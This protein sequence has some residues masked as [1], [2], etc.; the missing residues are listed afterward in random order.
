MELFLIETFLAER[1]EPVIGKATKEPHLDRRFFCDLWFV[2]SWFGCCFLARSTHHK[3]STIITKSFLIKQTLPPFSLIDTPILTLPYLTFHQHINL[4]IMCV[5]FVKFSPAAS[6]LGAAG[7]HKKQIFLS[8]SRPAALE[9]VKREEGNKRVLVQ[10]ETAPCSKR[11][12]CASS[13][14]PGQK[15]TRFQMDEPDYDSTSDDMVV[16]GPCHCDVSPE[17]LWWSR[18]ELQAIRARNVK[19]ARSLRQD[20]VRMDTVRIYLCA[21]NQAG[22]SP[23]PTAYL[24]TVHLNFGEFRGLEHGFV[25]SL[26]SNRKSHSQTLLKAQQNLKSHYDNVDAER[27]AHCS[28]ESSRAA[29]IIAALMAREDAKEAQQAMM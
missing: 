6:P 26:R 17:E 14:R 8:A 1:V 25:P 19:E 5:G 21:Y 20:S 7:S 16:P 23:A 2:H 28:M 18:Q 4:S 15:R 12:R 3:P 11:P 22:Y 29:G 24:S 9:A 27:M 10:K 13:R